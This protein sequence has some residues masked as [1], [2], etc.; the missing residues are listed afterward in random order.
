MIHKLL[1]SLFALACMAMPVS[2]K[3]L[4]NITTSTEGTPVL[5]IDSIDCRKDL[6]RVYGKLTGT[7]HTSSRIDRVS[8]IVEGATLESTDIDGVDFG[9]Y[10]QWEDEGVINIELDFPAIRKMPPEGQIVMTT[11]RGTSKATWKQAPKVKRKH[12]T[13][14]Q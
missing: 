5:M 11:P 13:R 3:M 8:L 10:F 4:R 1:V 12:K 6:V 9:R 7:P 2:G 14:R